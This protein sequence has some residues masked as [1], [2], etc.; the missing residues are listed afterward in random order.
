MKQL[1]CE[2]CGST[3][4]I[5][6]E[7]VFICQ[8]CGMKYSVEEAKKMMIEGT[9]DVRGTVRVDTSGELANLYQIARRARDDNNGENAAK[10]YDMILV[11]DPNSWEA[12]F[13]L[14]YFKAT[15]CKIAQIRSAA[16]SVGNC[17][18]SVLRLIRDHV[19]EDEQAAAV[20]EVMLR[21]SLIANMLSNGAKSHYD[22]ISSSIRKDYTQEYVDNVCAARD[23]MYT[24]GTVIDEIFGNNSEIGPLA[25]DAW[26][27]GIEIHTQILPYVSDVNGNR[28]S[29]ISYAE[30]IGK[31]DP[32]YS[33]DFIYDENQKILEDELKKLKKELS[34]AKT[35][36]AVPEGAKNCLGMGVFAII[37]GL[38][39]LPLS[40]SVE[41]YWGIFICLGCVGI[42]IYFAWHGGSEI[43]WNKEMAESHI[44]YLK[45][46]IKTKQAELD[47][48]EK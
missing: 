25:A 34:I 40:I 38:I 24:C 22:E 39:V 33:K 11:K 26:K 41:M 14:V 44:E 23:I 43:K 15:E 9:V 29:M 4:M 47:D 35:S 31:Y 36:P 45:S 32:E 48:L 1:T 18:D 16:I 12:S 10:Y 17:E 13:Y 2:M 46:V 42:G 30:E 3:D 20:Q 28:R 8:T 6:Q 7:G 19:A 21:S 5:K 37:L 27:S